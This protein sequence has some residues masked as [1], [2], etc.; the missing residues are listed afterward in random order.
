MTDITDI[1]PS[2]DL[3]PA[4]AADL[5]HRH[6][7]KVLHKIDDDWRQKPSRRCRAVTQD[8]V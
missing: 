7:Y 4:T 2:R 5:T 3:L 8:R 1:T 6:H